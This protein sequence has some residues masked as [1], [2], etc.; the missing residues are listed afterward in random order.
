MRRLPQTTAHFMR[1]IG[2]VS[3]VKPSATLFWSGGN[4]GD[5]TPHVGFSCGHRTFLGGG[6]VHRQ[7]VE[8]GSHTHGRLTVAWLSVTGT[9]AKPSTDGGVQGAI[10]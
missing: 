7:T 2:G 6:K 4:H 1:L 9:R 5:M 10:R 3:T 8:F